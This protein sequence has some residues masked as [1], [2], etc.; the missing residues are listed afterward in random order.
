MVY[1]TGGIPGTDL[2]PP[3]LSSEDETHP[4]PS[5]TSHPRDLRIAISPSNGESDG[6]EGQKQDPPEGPGGVGLDPGGDRRATGNTQRTYRKVCP[7][8]HTDP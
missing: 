3:P 4:S 2:T 1:T 5:P 8:T 6:Q 7:T